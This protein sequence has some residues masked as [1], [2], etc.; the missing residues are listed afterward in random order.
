MSAVLI[1]GRTEDACCQLIVQHLRDE[2]V[3]ALFVPENQLFPQLSLTWLPP[4]DGWV[5]YQD[6]RV[7]FDDVEAVLCRSY[8]IPVSPE[9]YETKDGQY[10]TAE[11]NALLMAWLHHMP[12]TVVNRLRAELWYR[13]QLTVPDLLMLAPEAPFRL[14][15]TLVTTSGADARAFWESVDG[16][17]SYSPLTHDAVYPIRNREDLEKLETLARSLPMRMTERVAGRRVHAFITGDEVVLVAPGGD[18]LD[19]PERTLVERCTAVGS[20]LGLLFYRL[21]L[22]ETP[23]GDWYCHGLDR[24]PPF[25]PYSSAAQHEI[26]ARLARAMCSPAAVRR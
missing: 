6:G 19:V 13:P 23:A 3:S 15:Q 5:T 7:S 20:A 11:W 22:I 12:C 24:L 17:A 8:G 1:I 4:G 10:V 26:A 9:E 18:L 2:G 14:P 21:S 16:R 25:Y